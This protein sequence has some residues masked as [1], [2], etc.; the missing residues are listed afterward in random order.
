MKVYDSLKEV[1]QESL[2]RS[3]PGPTTPGPVKGNNASMLTDTIEEFE[4]FVTSRI[5]RLKV[6]VNESAAMAASDARHAEQVIDD[7]KTKLATLEAK[8]RQSEDTLRSKDIANQK[9]EESLTAK[10]VALEAKLRETEE[11][12]RGKDAIIQGLEQNTNTRIQDLEYQLKTKEKLLISRSKEVVDLKSELNRL[13]NGIKEMSS[14]FRQSEVLAT[15]DGQNNSAVSS[16]GE[17]NAADEKPARSQVKG[18]PAAATPP[19]AADENVSPGFFKQLT[20][21]LT[22][23]IGPMAAMIV[24]DHVNALGETVESFPKVRVGELL[25][26]ISAEISDEKIKNG[27]RERFAQINGHQLATL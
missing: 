7:L 17:A 27:F 11:I 12:V 8:H 10:I 1:V 5:G 20:I 21:E 19:D 14:F 22:Q 18:K 26:T 3:K 25:E 23:I 2:Q 9:T 16:K 15:V 4:K 13:K 6:A 24:R